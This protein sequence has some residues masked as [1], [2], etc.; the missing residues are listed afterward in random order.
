MADNRDHQSTSSI[1]L[2]NQ[3]AGEHCPRCADSSSCRGSWTCSD[4]GNDTLPMIAEDVSWQLERYLQQA[5]RE[6]PWP[7]WILEGQAF[8][9]NADGRE[10]DNQSGGN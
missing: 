2:P 4:V 7:A 9:E 8:C 5:S 3:G 6:E 10:R 1:I